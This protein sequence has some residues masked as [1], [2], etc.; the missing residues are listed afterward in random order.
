MIF[1]LIFF[2]IIATSLSAKDRSWKTDF[3][4][5]VE[6]GLY[7]SGFDGTIATVSNESASFKDDFGYLKSSSSY[8]GADLNFG[9]SY[10]PNISVN[11]LNAVQE[12]SVTLNR[13]ISIVNIPFSGQATTQIQYEVLDF[14]LSYDIKNKGDRISLFGNKFYPGDITYSFGANIKKTLWNFQIIDREDT[15]ATYKYVTLNSFVPLPYLGF[16]YYYYYLS[17]YGNMSA[18]SFSE[19]KSMNYEVGIDFQLL[20]GFYLNASYMYESFEALEKQD[21][22]NFRT[23]GNKFSFKYK[24]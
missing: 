4:T 10:I 6:A 23:S 16:K 12:N 9:H 18:I 13:T 17:L 15:T 1:R 7:I 5:K 14:I 11:Y 3:K 21:T 2:I 8:F 20:K 19:V 22:I 24:F